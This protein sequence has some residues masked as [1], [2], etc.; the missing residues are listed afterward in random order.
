MI[1]LPRHFFRYILREVRSTT[2]EAR[3]RAIFETAGRDGAM[4]FCRLFRRHHGSTPKEAVE[5]YLLQV[6]LRG[7][8]RL[9]A[10]I[11]DLDRVEISIQNSAL[12]AEGDV[13]DGHSMWEGVAQGIL[14]FL[15]TEAGLA[16][17]PSPASVIQEEQGEGQTPP[18]FRIK[19]RWSDSKVSL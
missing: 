14:I 1:L 5:G 17:S 19:T 18:T 15:R 7:W 10:E 12:A 6:S 4:E 8:G 2:D 16:T 13:P 11:L 3:Y 9:R